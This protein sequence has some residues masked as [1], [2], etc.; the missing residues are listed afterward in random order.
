[1]SAKEKTMG[2]RLWELT[3][4]RLTGLAV[5]MAALGYSLGRRLEDLP[6]D[7]LSFYAM[8][9]GTWLVGVSCSVL[10]Q[11]LEQT[12]DARMKR[13][14]DRPLPSGAF[15]PSLAL[16]IGIASGLIGVI[17]LLIGTN[18]LTAVLGTATILFYLG[19][20]TPAKRL[21]SLSTLVGA[22]PGAMP[23]LLGWTAATGVLTP[24][25]FLLFAI[26][27]LWQVPHFLA[28]A[29]LH[30]DDYAR[31]PFPVLPVTDPTGGETAW[32]ALVYTLALL[33]VTLLPAYWGMAGA[34]YF[35]GALLL[36][37]GLLTAV[38]S[39]ARTRA[40]GAARRLFLLT[41]VYLPALGVLMLWDVRA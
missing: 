23:P 22:I 5:L 26:L 27:F 10:N 17:T 12:L 14:A 13:T 32:Q 40:E 19:V 31:A 24:E 1:M 33:P 35:F 37:L 36:G 28:I 16:K 9:L 7:N 8:L 2:A 3:K 25:G 21:S 11:Y 34:A 4:P 18:V 29:W 41:L 38:I 30:R 6:S 20:Y 39:L 15:S